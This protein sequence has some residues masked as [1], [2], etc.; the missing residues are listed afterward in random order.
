[1]WKSFFEY[2][3]LFNRKEK[4]DNYDDSEVYMYFSPLIDYMQ[5]NDIFVLNLESSERILE[6]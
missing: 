2:K 5:N 1:M 4:K 6:D 3:H